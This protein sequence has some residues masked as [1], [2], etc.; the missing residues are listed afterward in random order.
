MHGWCLHHHIAEI[1]EIWINFSNDELLSTYVQGPYELASFKKY[2]TSFQIDP[3]HV[4]LNLG[5][6]LIQSNVILIFFKP[7][8]CK[9]TWKQLFRLL[10]CTRFLH[11][12]TQNTH[13]VDGSMMQPPRRGSFWHWQLRSAVSW[14]MPRLWP[15]SCATVDATP[16][17]LTRWS[18]STREWVR[19]SSCCVPSY[20]TLYSH[21][22]QQ[23]RQYDRKSFI[24]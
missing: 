19:I 4:E 2:S 10:L 7:W 23:E 17:T 11:Y 3:N 8:S 24:F 12:S 13:P 14:F 9:Q 22:K 20:I 15:S 5:Q 16:S 18:Y 6:L 1:R 21:Q